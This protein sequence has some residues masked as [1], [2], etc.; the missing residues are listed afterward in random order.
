MN[1]VNYV[2]I[3][4]HAVESLKTEGRYN[5]AS[6][7]KDV[8]TEYAAMREAIAAARDALNCMTATREMA[9]DDD[10]FK[11]E[12][13][14]TYIRAVIWNGVDQEVYDKLAAALAKLGA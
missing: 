9:M 7:L 3:L 12:L 4:E 14:E 13:D 8:A 10:L 5:Q 11:P 1:E 6:I 2:R